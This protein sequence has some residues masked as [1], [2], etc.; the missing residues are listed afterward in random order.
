MD[1]L[2]IRVIVFPLKE[3][4][5]LSHSY[6]VAKLS[7]KTREILDEKNTASIS[8]GRQSCPCAEPRDVSSCGKL[9]RQRTMCAYVFSTALSCKAEFPRHW[10]WPC[11]SHLTSL[12]LRS[13]RSNIWKPKV[14]PSSN[15]CAA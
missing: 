15:C 4:R 5:N 11:A 10:Q 7:R 9:C 2:V 3:P 13:L 14:S 1:I 8:Q 6:M 12:Q